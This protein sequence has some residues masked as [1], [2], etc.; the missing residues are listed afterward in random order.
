[1]IVTEPDTTTRRPSTRRAVRAVLPS[2]DLT[3]AELPMSARGWRAS[4]VGLHAIFL[5]VIALAAGAIVGQGLA[6]DDGW[7]LAALGLLAVA[8]LAVGARAIATRSRA[9]STAYLIVLVMTVGVIAASTPSALFV[10]FLAYVQVWFMVERTVEGIVWTAL[11]AVT[12][13]VGLTIAAAGSGESPVGAWAS[14][15]ISF[16][17][18]VL[19]GLWVFRVLEQSQQRAEL[20]AQL[21]ATR[22]EL[23]AV[24][25][26][27]GMMAE[28]ERL[29]REVHD[30]LAQGY[31]SIVMLAQTA[32]A[33]LPES[34]TRERL[35]LIEE[36]A[37]DNLAEARRLVAA[38]RPPALDAGTVLDAI[39]RI[40]DRFGRE[41]A[42]AVDVSLPGAVE[43]DRDAE[44]V[45]VRAVQELLAN[46]RRH[47]RA[48]AVRVSLTAPAGEWIEL[49]VADDG[50]GFDP[51]A[52][53]TGVGLAG[54]RD[55]VAQVGGG[56]DIDIDIDSSADADS[57]A[58]TTVT[59][60]IP[61]SR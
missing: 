30:T 43:I 37:R 11:I 31:T 27:Q 8:Y 52:P 24:H 61:G 47:A 21:E 40:A 28:R 16:L 14:S 10:L 26:E 55:R 17:F 12:S 36:V 18:S 49:T 58:G 13:A 53:V 6:G 54:L 25:H 45:L 50:V 51:S 60:R 56:V 7:A 41:T 46:V 39:A 59:V 15:G 1:M 57:S 23:A 4:V 9:R 42:L 34:P 48:S 3:P 29:A 44:V 35:E 19:M 2:P 32:V 38:F 5:A 20:I 33:T 22:S